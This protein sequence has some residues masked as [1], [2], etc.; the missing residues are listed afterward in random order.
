MARGNGT[1]DETWLAEDAAA[2]A[3]ESRMESAVASSPL[4]SGMADEIRRYVRDE[5]SN[6]GYEYVSVNEFF[7]RMVDGGA[8]FVS[9]HLLFFVIVAFI[10]VASLVIAFG[11]THAMVMVFLAFILLAL[12]AAI[13]LYIRW[14]DWKDKREEL[15]RAE[16]LYKAAQDAKKKQAEAKK[17]AKAVEED[18]SKEKVSGAEAAAATA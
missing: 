10:V 8:E 16:M 3:Y 11:R 17:A 4:L 9:E 13:L 18:A 2:A 15:A 7:R 12:L 1:I 14:Q 6:D 5:E